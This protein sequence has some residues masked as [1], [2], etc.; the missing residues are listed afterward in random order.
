MSPSPELQPLGVP[1]R[2]AVRIGG[3]QLE[4]ARGSVALDL[5]DDPVL[6]FDQRRELRQ[7]HAAD[8]GQV[9]LALQHVGESCE[10]GLEPIL[11]GIAIGGQ[12]QVPDHRIDVVFELGDL[13]A[14][15]HLHGSGQ[16]A[17]GDCGRHLGDGAHLGSQVRGEQIDV[18]RQILP[19]ARRAGHVRLAAQAPLNAHLACDGGHLIG[20]GGQRV[21]HVVDG[22][23]QRRD[24]ALG[25]DGEILLQ[26]AVRNRGHHLDDAA[27]LLGQVRRHDVDGVGKILPSAGDPGHLSLAAE[28]ALGTDLARHPRDFAGEAVQLVDH[29]I[30]GVL[31]LENLALYVHGDLAR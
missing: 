8:G 22:L 7:Q 21:G 30:D 10:I 3:Q 16:V 29:R 12:T 19:G 14:R 9:T 5:V 13:A 24:F 27:H 31:E 23:G 4:L 17:L 1:L 26:I 11:F 28:P 25:G 6:R 2:A 20:E 15:L 18:A